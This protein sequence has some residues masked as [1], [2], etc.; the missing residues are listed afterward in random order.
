[1]HGT[2]TKEL[3]YHVHDKLLYHI[4]KFCI[5]QSERVHVI[6]EAHT[7][8]IFGHFGIGKTIYQLQRYCY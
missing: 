8:L 7:S 2:Q 4:G 5:P 1:M 6:R 3:N